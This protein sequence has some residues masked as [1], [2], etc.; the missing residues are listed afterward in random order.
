MFPCGNL[1]PENGRLSGVRI[2]AYFALAQNRVLWPASTP[3]AP[4]PCGYSPSACPDLR[5]KAVLVDSGSSATRA[6][7]LL[8]RG[9]L[10]W[11]RGRF[12]RAFR[13]TT[14]R[15]INQLRCPPVCF[16]CPL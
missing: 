5:G 8:G 3:P 12:G 7:L 6:F 15:I 2:T 14:Y 11:R 4:T 1:A 13:L 10:G 9:R 16:R